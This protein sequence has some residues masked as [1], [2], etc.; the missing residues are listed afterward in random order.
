MEQDS[1]SHGCGP[2]NDTQP[3]YVR[4]VDEHTGVGDVRGMPYTYEHVDERPDPSAS[5]Y[6]VVGIVHYVDLPLHKNVHYV[7]ARRFDEFMNSWGQHGEELV[8]VQ[9]MTYLEAEQEFSNFSGS[10]D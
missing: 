7:E 6:R 8:D 9:R 1:C 2:E 3:Y 5:V 4:E 10:D